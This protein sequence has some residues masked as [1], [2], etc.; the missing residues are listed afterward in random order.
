[1]S[2]IKHEQLSDFQ[3]RLKEASRAQSP[4]YS[5]LEVVTK[6]FTMIEQARQRNVSWEKITQILNDS[7]GRDLSIQTVK[8]YYFRV[9]KAQKEGTAQPQTAP[10]PK[11]QASTRKSKPQNQFEAE[12][13]DTAQALA[14]A[15][16]SA[17]AIAPNDQPAQPGQS[18]FERMQDIIA[19]SNGFNVQ[20]ETENP[21][22]TES[23]A[24]TKS[25][26][27]F[28]TVRTDS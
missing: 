18:E 12:V 11:A 23:L 9:Q 20:P 14:L 19:S 8:N 4:V 10:L 5:V 3:K 27:N 25:R 1:M 22:L 6:A 21:S 17:Q 26:F 24:P 13:Q 15:Q 16:V 28:N 2:N 7:T